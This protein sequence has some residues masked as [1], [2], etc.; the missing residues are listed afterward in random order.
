LDQAT[1]A[2]RSNGYQDAQLWASTIL[3]A[4]IPEIEYIEELT[5]LEEMIVEMENGL[6]RDVIE[7]IYD[8]LVQLQDSVTKATQED[9]RDTL[10][11]TVRNMGDARDKKNYC[12]SY[13]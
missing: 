8:T 1:K 10:V 11:Y 7:A 6:E 3:Q 9:I 13:R 5:E 12:R 2:L 4:M